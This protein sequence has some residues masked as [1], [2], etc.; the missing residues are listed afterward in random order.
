MLAKIGEFTFEFGSTDLDTIR[1]RFSF[2]W[3]K[4]ERLGKSPTYQATGSWEEEITLDGQLVMKSVR[5]LEPFEA[6]A[7]AKEPVRLTLGSGESY[8]VIIDGLERSK[9]GFT[10]KGLFRK[11]SYSI[12]IKR[13]F[14]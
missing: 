11:Q 14:E 6:M 7:K 9:S 1:H 13:Y 4:H 3:R 12:S 2:A 8:M 5:T 10:T